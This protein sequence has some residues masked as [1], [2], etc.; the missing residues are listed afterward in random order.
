VRR[1]FFP[2]PSFFLLLILSSLSPAFSQARPSP[3]D[4][5]V[6][7]RMVRD[8]AISFQEGEKAIVEWADRFEK[9]YL[10]APFQ[11]STF[12][13]LEGYSIKDVGGKNGDGYKP[14]G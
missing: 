5:Q 6:F 8:G 1:S 13:P 3:A 7:E 11:E 10:N 9:E 2:W 12:F 4:W 14:E